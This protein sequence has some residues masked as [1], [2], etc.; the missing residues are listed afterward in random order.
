MT[1][2]ELREYL[3]IAADDASY[4]DV[5]DSLYTLAKAIF[6]QN[7]RVTFTSETVTESLIDF[8]SDQIFL[9]V[10]PVDSITSIFYIDDLTSTVD[11]AYTDF[12]LVDNVVYLSA[13]LDYKCLDITYVAGYASIPAAIDQ[14]LVQLVS[15]MWTFN[16]SKVFLSGSSEVPL[17]PNDVVIPKYIRESMAI[18]RVGF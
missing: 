14:V 17:V 12:K 7:T 11:T 4:D 18:Y 8:Y 9:N 16:D 1:T 13:M 15:F 10:C 3:N 6:T 2:I 5:I